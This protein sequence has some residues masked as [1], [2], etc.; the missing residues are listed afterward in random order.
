[1]SVTT[2]KEPRSRRTTSEADGRHTGKIAKASLCFKG[3]DGALRLRGVRG[4][5]Q[6]TCATRRSGSLAMCDQPGMMSK[7]A[8]HRRVPVAAA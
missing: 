6:V 2:D 5:D 3:D 4:D 8:S 1:M 7:R